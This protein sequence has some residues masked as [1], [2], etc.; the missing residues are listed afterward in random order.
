MNDLIIAEVFR[1]VA[2]DM[3]NTAEFKDGDGYIVLERVFYGIA[4][5]IERVSQNDE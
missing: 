3:T 2:D 4:D 1:Q 5:R